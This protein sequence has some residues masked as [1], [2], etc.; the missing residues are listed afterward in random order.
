MT[1]ISDGEFEKEVI[2]ASKEKGIVV[3][4]W[5]PW[6]GPCQVLKP[7]LEN[8]AKDY[9]DK[10]TLV[11]VNVDEHKENASKFGVM[12]IPSVKLFKDGKVV[13]EFVGSQPD[14]KIREWLNKEL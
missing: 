13:S 12:S 10:M 1:D 9:T 2:E 3:D 8:I 11:K 14:E 6:C 7:V 5:A 4:F